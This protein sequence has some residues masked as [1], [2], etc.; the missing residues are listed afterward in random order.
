VS[1]ISRNT[2]TT[3]WIFQD[4]TEFYKITFAGLVTREQALRVSREWRT[5]FLYSE[6]KH[7]VIFDTTTLIEM[8]PTARIHWQQ[9]TNELE[10][11]IAFL[12]II[13]NSRIMALK[14]R[15]MS[16]FL[17]FPVKVVSSMEK[18]QWHSNRET[19]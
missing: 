10:N 7:I 12:W 11:Q 3:E 6:A 2:T 13:S 5:Q 15:L 19:L 4:S 16:L 18:I 14:A 9:V 17:S 1:G 8:E